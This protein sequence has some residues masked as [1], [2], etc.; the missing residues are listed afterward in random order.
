MLSTTKGI[1][2]AK[3]VGNPKFKSINL[4]IKNEDQEDYDDVYSD[5]EEIDI[6][7][8]IS[9]DDIIKYRQSKKTIIDNVP[10][11]FIKLLKER[12]AKEFHIKEGELQQIPN[13]RHERDVLYVAGPSGSGKST[14][15]GQYLRNYKKTYPKNKIIVF[16]KVGSDEA[17]DRIKD[18]IRIPIDENLI[19][20]PVEMSELS[21]S[22]VVFDDIDVIS[23]KRV[24]ETVQ[25]I[26]DNTL[27]IG[28]HNRIS[29]CATS[30]Q[31]MNYKLTRTMI[32]EAHTVTV[33]PRS[34]STYHIKRFLKE[35]A[36][37][38]NKQMNRAMSLPSRWI[39]IH[40]NYPIY[41]MYNQGVYLV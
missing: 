7:D 30:H 16:S 20:D 39:T 19:E 5:N 28:R 17:F 35:Y 25:H 32:N 8:I 38:D 11:K 10:E 6:Y 29:V 3:I 4:Y 41:V 18:V 13:L 31:L 37:F 36:G 34:G 21:D 2:I 23:D 1:P 33:F 14:Y 22:C 27:E 40:K 26:R 12:E 15:I 9:E 24:R